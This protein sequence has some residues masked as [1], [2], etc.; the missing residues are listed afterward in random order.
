[1]TAVT[2]APGRHG[3]DGVRITFPR[4]V[5]SE[6][7]RFRSLKSSWIILAVTMLLLVGLAA[8]A[9]WARAS[10]WPPENR[11]EV[12]LFNPTLQSIGPGTFFGQLAVGV[13]GVLMVTGEYTTGMV[14]ATMTSVPRRLPVMLARA[15]VFASLT[16]AV[17]IPTAFVAF[18][19]GQEL[20]SS[21]GIDTTLSAPNVVRAVVGAG[22]YLVAIGLLGMGLGW[23][24]RHTAGA[25][26]TLFGMLLILPI[27]VHFLPDPWPADV[28][29]WLPG[30]LDGTAGVAVWNTRIG[31]NSLGPWAGFGMLMAYVAAVL[32]IAAVLLRRRDV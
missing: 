24:L 2:M 9:C 17:L 18:L 10:H 3:T 28:T 26:T 4:I 13:L 12:F 6:W 29:K 8:L 5:R 32:V 27:V 31:T 21:K 22:L 7:I 15:L 30:G 19:V 14:R 1:M 25:I 16:L 20:L 23:L 11:A